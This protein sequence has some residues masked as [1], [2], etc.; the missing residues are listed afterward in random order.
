MV[1]D[2]LALI[3]NMNGAVRNL[4][5]APP[6]VVKSFSEMAIAAHKGETP[7]TARPRN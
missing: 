5:G 3:N 1:E 4:R 7:S 6:E 2:W